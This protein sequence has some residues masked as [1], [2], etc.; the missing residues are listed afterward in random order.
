MNFYTF[1]LMWNYVAVTSVL[2]KAPEKCAAESSD[3]E[4]NSTPKP[5]NKK[6]G[7]FSALAVDSD[8]DME[9]SIS[10]PVKAAKSHSA[11]KVKG[12]FALLE[13]EGGADSDSTTEDMGRDSEQENSRN[14][15]TKRTKKVVQSVDLEDDDFSKKE[16]KGGKKGKKQRKKQQDDDEDIEKMLAELEMEYSGVKKPVVQ[17]EQPKE[18]GIIE[19]SSK[20]EKKK[21]KKLDAEKGEMVEDSQEKPKEIVDGEEIEGTVKSAAQKRKE[22]KEK[23]KQKKMAQ[24]K[25]VILSLVF[26]L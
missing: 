26:C 18:E 3:E 23:E 4:P 8:S 7:G 12:G 13:V 21:K 15:N 14:G 16:E 2:Q 10:Q 22:K 25:Q 24:K 20:K 9:E 19:E 1:N 11:H 17:E 6:K 5:L